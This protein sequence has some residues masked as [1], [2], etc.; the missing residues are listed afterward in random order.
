MLNACTLVAFLATTKPEAAKTFFGETLGLRLIEDATF[1][2]VF[3]SGGVTL[4]VQKVDALTPPIGTALGWKVPDMAVAMKTLSGKGVRFERFEGMD[5]DEAGVWVP[6][7]TSAKVCW[8]RDPDG[9]LLSL[10]ESA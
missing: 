9:N 10:T 5:Q 6:P 8:F 2:V 7:G 1:A 3:E 4:R